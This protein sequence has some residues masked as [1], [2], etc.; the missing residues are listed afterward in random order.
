MRSHEHICHLRR[1]K[2]AQAEREQATAREHG[3]AA[4]RAQHEADT[5][6]AAAAACVDDAIVTHE[7]GLDRA[8]LFDRL[9]TL[10]VARAHVLESQHR[11]GEL[12]QQAA[13]SREQAAVSLRLAVEHRRRS[14]KLDEWLSRQQ[15]KRRQSAERRAEWETQED[16]ACRRR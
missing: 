1:W 11:V 9:R 14:N 8:A 16:Y 5:L 4:A 7:L 13:H 3:E 6:R 10:A 2:R 12:S 15:R